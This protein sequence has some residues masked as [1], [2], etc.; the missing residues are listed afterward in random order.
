MYPRE[1]TEWITSRIWRPSFKEVVI[2]KQPMGCK[3]CACFLVHVNT[4]P[5][6]SLLSPFFLYP[7]SLL[8]SRER[9]TVK[10][11]RSS[12]KFS[13][14]SSITRK[15]WLFC[16]PHDI[17]LQTCL[18]AWSRFTID[19]S[20]FKFCKCYQQTAHTNTGR[21]ACLVYL[22]LSFHVFQFD[23]YQLRSDDVFC[24]IYFAKGSLLEPSV[25]GDGDWR[26]T[27][28]I[29]LKI[30]HLP[31]IRLETDAGDPGGFVA[32]EDISLSNN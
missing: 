2:E 31:L 23:G 25:E 14:N 10:N 9:E 18:Q 4:L 15:L 7:S 28:P 5:S 6:F 21:V 29:F 12:A 11:L 1:W 19:T 13:P 17:N 30:C 20:S 24:T 32:A 3:E 27:C 16:L 8:Y 26:P 22:P